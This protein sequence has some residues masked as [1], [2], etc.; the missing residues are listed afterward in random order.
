MRYEKRLV[1]AA[2]MAGACQL[3]QAFGWGQY[4]HEQ[5]NQVAVELLQDQKHPMATCFNENLDTIKRLAITPDM[6]WKIMPGTS[7]KDLP[8]SKL[9]ADK[10]E[11][12][13]HYFEAD[14]F[15]ADASKM[16]SLPA[17]E[18]RDVYPQY[19]K[20]LQAN[21]ENVKKMDKKPLEA[22]AHGTAPWRILQLYDLAVES[23]KANDQAKA[24]LY[25]GALGHYVGDMSQPFHATLDY[26]GGGY[27]RPASGIHSTFEEKILEDAAGGKKS[28][29]Q[30]TQIWDTAATNN[31]V[32]SIA[33][34]QLANIVPLP[35]ERIVP[36]V[37]A[38]VASG[39]P[40]VEI[41]LKD[42][43]N[44]CAKAQSGELS[45]HS[46][47]GG[48]AKP[49]YCVNVAKPGSHYAKTNVPA[50]LIKAFRNAAVEENSK[51]TGLELAEQRMAASS[52][53][54]ARIW[55][56]A[57]AAAGNPE[58]S[59]NYEFDQLDVNGNYPM[60]TFLPEADAGEYND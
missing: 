7:K 51:T 37:I 3:P 39:Y 14:A 38:L 41:L 1:M 56:S 15:T 30:S 45:L 8:Q 13:L 59:G 49:Q 47:G 46:R 19:Q 6:D 4:G 12:P 31:R 35:R 50:G 20:L 54:L 2:M 55:I 32:H 25:L 53:L 9:L 29:N 36:E 60:P 5:I 21:S 58:I 42:F 10:A 43:S 23:L 26:D 57:Y 34:A 40:D 44:L 52:V 22:T 27:P 48:E 18:Y 11:H 16:S 17:G 33:Q 24:I 28:K